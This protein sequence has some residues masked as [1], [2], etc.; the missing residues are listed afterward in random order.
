M[1]TTKC[2]IFFNQQNT[3]W[4]WCYYYTQFAGKKVKYPIFVSKEKGG[5]SEL[6][7]ESHFFLVQNIDFAV[8]HWPFYSSIQFF[9]S[10]LSLGH[11]L[12][13]LG[14][15]LSIGK[16]KVLV[17]KKCSLDL[18]TNSNS[19]RESHAAW[20]WWVWQGL[21]PTGEYIPY[22]KMFHLSRINNKFLA[23]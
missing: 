20:H 8:P 13:V 6:H 7:R 14:W 2:F 18:S 12:Q 17:L 21:R 22:L 4:G 15:V 3:L 10:R 5:K 1:P 16:R 19:F 23:I 11:C 9:A